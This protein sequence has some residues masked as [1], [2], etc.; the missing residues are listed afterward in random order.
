VQNDGLQD[1]EEAVLQPLLAMSLTSTQLCL[2]V[3]AS[4]LHVTTTLPM[5]TQHI[6]SRYPTDE[7]AVMQLTYTL[8]SR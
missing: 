3:T 1:V 4:P 8:A 6:S 2:P 5:P 7:A